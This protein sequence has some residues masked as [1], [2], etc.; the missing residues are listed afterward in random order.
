MRAAAASLER[1]GHDR[2]GDRRHAPSK[3][4]LLDGVAEDVPTRRVTIAGRAG[5]CDV[6]AGDG[7]GFLA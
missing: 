3:A 2:G 5:Y 7:A 1:P 4:P 6:G